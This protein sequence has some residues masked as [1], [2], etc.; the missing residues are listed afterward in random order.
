MGFLDVSGGGD[1]AAGYIKLHIEELSNLCVSTFISPIR[2]HVMLLSTEI[3]L[4]SFDLH[5]SEAR[6]YI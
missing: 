2:R 4:F 6:P 1:V 5:A 3:V